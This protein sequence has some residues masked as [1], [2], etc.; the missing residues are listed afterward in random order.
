MEH[1]PRKSKAKEEQTR[2]LNE[3]KDVVKAEAAEVRA[4]LWLAVAEDGLE[5][6]AVRA[7]AA[8]VSL[9]IPGNGG[10]WKASPRA[11][12]PPIPPRCIPSK[13]VKSEA[14]KCGESHA[15]VA[16]I[17]EQEDACD[18]CGACEKSGWSGNTDADGLD[19]PDDEF[20]YADFVAREFGGKSSKQALT[21]NV[22]WWVAL[23]LLIVLVGAALLPVFR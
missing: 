13:K 20:D 11:A 23:V 4:E 12:F 14:L 22:W 10:R 1:S 15:L 2:L 7:H 16:A 21:S 8:H 3:H 9:V 5:D 6:V 19:L 17:D 18:D